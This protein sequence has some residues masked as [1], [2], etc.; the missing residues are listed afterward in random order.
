MRRS[1]VAKVKNVNGVAY[2]T[3]GGCCMDSK[4][5]DILDSTF[6]E[7]LKKISVV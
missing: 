5:S 4:N 3:V 2:H 6:N 7:V 1:Q